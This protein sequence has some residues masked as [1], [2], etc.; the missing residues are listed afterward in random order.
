[1]RYSRNI[2][3]NYRPYREFYVS[4]IY[5]YEWSYVQCF[6]KQPVNLCEISS[7]HRGEVLGYGFLK[8]DTI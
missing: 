4:I 8:Y 6:Q 3:T 1:M 7:F 2:Q 5:T